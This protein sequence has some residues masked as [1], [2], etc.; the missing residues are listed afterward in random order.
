MTANSMATRYLSTD[1][2]LLA[3]NHFLHP[4]MEA[5]QEPEPEC[6]SSWNRLER[7]TQLVQPD[8]VETKYGGLDVEGA[9]A[10]L[11]DTY[12]P[13][14]QEY[15]DPGL[16][17]GGATLANNGAMQSVVFVPARGLMYVAIGKFPA[18]ILEFQGYDIQELLTGPG[19][20][21]PAPPSYPALSF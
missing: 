8:G 3:T 15:L 18:T 21:Y 16:A 4:D 1:G 10:I 19:Y 5:T 9:I 6:T 17:D 20:A 2:V 7:L 12:D 13:C 14:L 11:R